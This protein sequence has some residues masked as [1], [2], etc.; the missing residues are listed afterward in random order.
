M[1][2]QFVAQDTGARFYSLNDGIHALTSILKSFTSFLFKLP[3]QQLIRLAWII[4]GYILLRPYLELGFQKLFATQEE[5]GS[6]SIPAAAVRKGNAA[7]GVV[8]DFETKGLSSGTTTGSAAWGA[9]ARNRQAIIL[10][11]WEEEQARLA[12]E[13]DFD[14]IDPDLLEE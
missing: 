6:D 14:G 7:G 5:H 11:A 1:S 3:L 12:E 2:T 10:Q 9:A 13:R 4:G 8:D